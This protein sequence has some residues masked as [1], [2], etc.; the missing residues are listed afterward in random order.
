MRS[1]AK[2]VAGI[3]IALAIFVFAIFAESSVRSRYGGP[4]S[5]DGLPLHNASV[6]G[7]W[8]PDF[9]WAKKKR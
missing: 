8:T 2:V 5:I 7:T 4:M 1:K 9:L 6:T 3:A